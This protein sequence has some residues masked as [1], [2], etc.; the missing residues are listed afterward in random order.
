M[1]R[2]FRFYDDIQLSRS[3]SVT[4]LHSTGMVWIKEKIENSG[5]TNHGPKTRDHKYSGLIDS[6]YDV[7]VY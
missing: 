1:R 6:Y 3:S 5:L 2:R 7:D 4:A